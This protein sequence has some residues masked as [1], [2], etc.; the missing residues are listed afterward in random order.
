M[1]LKLLSYFVASSLI[2]ISHDCRVTCE[3]SFLLLMCESILTYNQFRSQFK[4]NN[5]TCVK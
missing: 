5:L 4:V 3:Q 2:A 1:Y